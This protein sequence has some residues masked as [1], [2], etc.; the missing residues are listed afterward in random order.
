MEL[1]RAAA[2]GH[3]DAVQDLLCKVYV[4]ATDDDHHTALHKA[5]EHGRTSVVRLLLRRGAAVDFGALRGC[6]ALHMASEQGHT[7]VVQLLLNAGAALNVVNAKGKT[8]MHLAAC[9]GH[10]A[11]VQLLLEAGAACCAQYI[12]YQQTASAPFLM[13]LARATGQWYSCC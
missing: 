9:Q 6:T 3:T 12:L 11:V 10:T 8:A 13:Q 4:N 1:H 5:A 2:D 7:D